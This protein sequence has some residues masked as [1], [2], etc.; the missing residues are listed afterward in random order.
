MR[1]DARR[2]SADL[3]DGTRGTGTERTAAV[4][5][6]QRGRDRDLTQR[7]RLAISPLLPLFAQHTVKDD[8]ER[9]APFDLMAAQ[10]SFVLH[11]HLLQ[12]ASR[13]GVAREMSRED[14]L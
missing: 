2:K 9:L 1:A 11:P 13:R 14:A 10:R 12:H 8:I 5:Q 6:Q 3:E 4:A 7:A